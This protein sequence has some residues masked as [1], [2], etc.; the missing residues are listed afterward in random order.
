VPDVIRTTS[1][2]DS[3]VF[4]RSKADF[5][6]DP[7][8]QAIPGFA[9]SAAHREIV[10]HCEDDEERRTYVQGYQ[11]EA[12][13]IAM[14]GNSKCSSSTSDPARELLRKIVTSPKFESAVCLLIFLNSVILGVQT[15][16]IAQQNLT[17]APTE[18]LA[19]EGI[20]CVFFVAELAL[21]A[22]VYKWRFFQGSGW[23]WNVFDTVII[24]VQVIEQIMTAIFAGDSD[25]VVNNFSAT[26]VIRTLKLIRL[27][28]IARVLHVIGELRI[29]II[30][31]VNSV[32][33]L[34]WTVVLLMFMIYT[35]S[36]YL[37]QMVTE[38]RNVLL[39]DSEEA[40]VLDRHFGSLGT[41]M[42]SMFMAITAGIDWQELCKPLMEQISPVMAPL[43]AIYIAFS[44]LAMLNVVTGVFVESVLKSQATDRDLFMVSNAR[45]LF[46]SLDGGMRA[47]MTWET[48][49]SKLD[50]PQMQ[51]FL[52]AIDVDPSEARG[53]FKLLDL[54]G[55]GE[56]SADEFLNGA[57]RLRG[58]AK[59]LD[60]ALLIQ[61][62]RNI[63]R[64]MR[65][66]TVHLS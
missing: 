50:A 29:L 5:G 4:G 40:T 1:E 16:L 9:N 15:D 48:F 27:L 47:H 39:P 18:L 60:V 34:F 2:N 42:L 54:D 3:E 10:S 65:Q 64:Q 13:E 31:I 45:E 61:E 12:Y 51:A 32:K 44:L 7:G 25:V 36:I 58:A 56:V 23:H 33:S 17:R 26:R 21:R 24:A 11:T 52:K 22:S 35:F 14:R 20:M 8:L 66:V 46:Q 38:R 53:L 59:A 43:F 49:E 41:T 55:S 6:P 28:R 30:S 19:L 37:T 57:L 62:V 63:E